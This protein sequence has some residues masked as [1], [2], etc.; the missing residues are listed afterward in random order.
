MCVNRGGRETRK[1]EPRGRGYRPLKTR[2]KISK[3]GMPTNG[4]ERTFL[5]AKKSGGVI[6]FKVR[7]PRGTKRGQTNAIRQTR[8]RERV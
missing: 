8:S 4:R 1:F 7:I 2:R 3:G 5:G 6:L